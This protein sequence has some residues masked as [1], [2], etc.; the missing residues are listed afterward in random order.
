MIQSGAEPE[1]REYVNLCTPTQTYQIRQVQCSNSLHVLRPSDGGA[2]RGDTNVVGEDDGLNL[3]ES[4]TMVAKCGSTLELHA[5]A[6]GFSAIPFL[7][8]SLQV[9]NRVSGGRDVDMDVDSGLM[10]LEPAEKRQAIE[11]YFADVPVSRAQCEKGWFELCAFVSR[12]ASD[13]RV[14]CW[15]PSSRAKLDVWKSIVDSAVLQGID[16]EK[17]F[18]ARDLWR[19]ILDDGGEE[20]FP[21]PLFDAVLKRVCESEDSPSSAV[22]EPKCE[23]T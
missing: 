2:Q 20:P 5:P 4:M 15:R 18:L 22:A 16:L 7:E 13:D 1:T 19:S 14:T 3:A 10:G 11:G 8:R 12:D 6:E 21:R 17:Q 23:S 9:Y